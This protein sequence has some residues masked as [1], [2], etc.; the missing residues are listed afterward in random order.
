MGGTV[1]GVGDLDGD[2][3]PRLGGVVVVVGIADG[4]QI[5]RGNGE[6]GGLERSGLAQCDN[7][8][9]SLIQPMTLECQ[10]AN[11]IDARHFMALN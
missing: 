11:S 9:H 10:A 5:C 1:L 8:F 6:E 7:L 4:D 3:G 2:D